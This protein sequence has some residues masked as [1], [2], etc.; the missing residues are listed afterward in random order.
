MKKKKKEG[1]AKNNP[2]ELKTAIKGAEN[3][4]ISRRCVSLCLSRQKK[5][6][7]LNFRFASTP[8]RQRV[9][10]VINSFTTVT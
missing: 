6:T 1:E 2:T 8:F 9:A 3:V 5:N 7:R 4:V 10:T